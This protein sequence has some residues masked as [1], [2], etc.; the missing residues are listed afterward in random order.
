MLTLTLT[1]SNFSVLR[2]LSNASKKVID[3]QCTFML[4]LCVFANQNLRLWSAFPRRCHPSVR[5]EVLFLQTFR[6]LDLLTFRRL[7]FRHRDEKRVTCRDFRPFF[8]YVC[9]LFHFPYPSTPLFATLTKQDCLLD[10]RKQSEQIKRKRSPLMTFVIGFRCCDGV[11]LCTDSLEADGVTKRFVDKTKI[12]GTSEWSVAIAGAGPG[13]FIDKFTSDV[14]ANLPREAYD[15]K[16]IES[17]IE[18]ALSRFRSQYQEPFRVLIGVQSP[19]EYLLYRSD[20]NYLSPINDHAH[21][22]V[23]HSLWRFLS[24]NLY[25]AG[26]SVDDNTR[27][28]ILIML[29]AEKYVDGVEGDIRV[30][31]YTF[32]DKSWKLRHGAEHKRARPIE[33]NEN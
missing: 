20:D 5:P 6:R 13:G 27:L 14:S 2:L 26:N 33:L 11:V 23:G 7:P 4:F 22:G 21:V 24:E 30:V 9:T 16:E 31:S 17:T 3:K 32:G 18:D 25:V 15:R 12:I 10:K 28:A 1:S 8:S 29:Q 19:N